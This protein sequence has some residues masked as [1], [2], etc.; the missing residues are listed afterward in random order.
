ML[1]IQLIDVGNFMTKL[2]RSEIFDSFLFIIVLFILFSFIYFIYFQVLN[3]PN[4]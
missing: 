1:A 4:I 2:L 3:G